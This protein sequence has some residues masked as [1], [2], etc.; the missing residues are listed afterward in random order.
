ME[1]QLLCVFWVKDQYC[2]NSIIV[3]V[4]KQNTYHFYKH[5]M[6]A[7]VILWPWHP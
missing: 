3:K 6:A 2:K 7:Q 5:Q 4:S 1:K